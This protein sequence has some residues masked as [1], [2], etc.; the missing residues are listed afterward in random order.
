MKTKLSCNLAM[1]PWFMKK[2]LEDYGRGMEHVSVYVG[3]V[4]FYDFS[5]QTAINAYLAY[6]F[7]GYIRKIGCTVRPYEI[8]A[9]TTD[10]VISRRSQGCDMHS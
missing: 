5:L 1:F 3:D 10:A 7:G 8:T 9:G 6:M 2:M 4:I